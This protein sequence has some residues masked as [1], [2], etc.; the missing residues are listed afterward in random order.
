MFDIERWD[1]KKN[2]IDQSKVNLNIIKS[3]NIESINGNLSMDKE[4]KPDSKLHG[5]KGMKCLLLWS[6]I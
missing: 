2:T 1:R 6:G 4:G 5:K 3:K